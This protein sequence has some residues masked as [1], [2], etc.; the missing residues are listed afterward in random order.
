MNIFCESRLQERALQKE[1]FK[2]EKKVFNGPNKHLASFSLE[3]YS[4][5]VKKPKTTLYFC[6]GNKK[7]FFQKVFISYKSFSITFKTLK[8]NSR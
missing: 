7:D 8:E 3:E 2:T 6:L 4:R 5:Q 1:T